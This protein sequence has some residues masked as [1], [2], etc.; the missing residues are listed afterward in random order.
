MQADK[1]RL[2]TLASESSLGYQN[3]QFSMPLGPTQV[4]HPDF[5]G[6]IAAKELNL[7]FGW[8]IEVSD[9]MG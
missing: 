3:F 1:R 7:G 4:Y 2:K 6:P 5:S 8:L 9:Q